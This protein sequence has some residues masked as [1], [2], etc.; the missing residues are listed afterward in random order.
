MGITPAG[1]YRY[2]LELLQLQALHP[3]SPP[4]AWPRCT[5]SLDPESFRRA[6]SS[7][8]DPTFAGLIYDGLCQGFRI[9]FNY[10]NADTLRSRG[11]NHPS[12][13][14]NSAVVS[15][16]I[17]NEVS[18]GRLVGPLSAEAAS[19]V[20]TSPI[21][22]VPKGHTTGRWRVIVDLSFP[23]GH[24]VND[25]M[26]RDLASIRY[27]SLDDAVHLILRLGPGT[28]LVKLD[29]KDAYRMVPV[30]P[31][32]QHLLGIQWNDSTYID[33]ALPFGLRTAPKIFT[34]VSDAMA[35][36]IANQGVRF[37]LHYLDDFLLLGAPHSNEA[38]DAKDSTLAVFGELGAPVA[39]HKTEGPS[40]SITFLGILIDTVTFQLKLPQDKLQRYRELLHSWCGRRAC[41]RPDLD[42]LVGYLSHAAS[43][44]RPG[45]LFLQEFYALLRRYQS[46][47]HHIRLNLAARADLQWWDFF[48]SEW[49][50]ISLF[51]PGPVTVH[52]HSDASGAIGCGT[53]D[54]TR[55]WFSVLWTPLWSSIEITAKELLPVVLAA[56][57][58]GPVWTGHHIRFHS[59]NLAVVTII[60]NLNAKDSLLCHLIR[61]LYFYAAHFNFKFSAS[62]V[63][64]IHNTAA[65]ALSRHNL[66]LF[67]SLFPQVPQVIIP[68]WL[69]SLFLQHHP[70]WTSRAWTSQFQTSLRQ[71]SLLQRPPHTQ[72]GSGVSSVSANSQSSNHFH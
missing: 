12:A 14:A 47:F 65:D 25:G 5:T 17:A 53:F 9:G 72:L 7:H 31:E 38:A 23:A 10:Q 55:G 66:L 2:T 28:Q 62:H 33:R 41:T 32:D 19:Q 37:V 68:Q 21:G 60:Q 58:W 64:G 70:E 16:H 35:W 49:N 45:R 44:V 63:A 6:L 50:G 29:L 3:L 42:S 46:P 27:T 13:L 8:P 26:D 69:H 1:H 51:P 48:L 30:H 71:A 15:S 18:A 4:L 34:A 11:N 56:A 24:S 54:P 22:L 40:T 52:V 57:I 20:H 67:T 39:V 61:C 43:V 36:A 59:D